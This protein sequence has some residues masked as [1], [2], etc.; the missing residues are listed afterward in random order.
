MFRYLKLYKSSKIKSLEQEILSLK[1]K[2]EELQQQKHV[3]LDEDQTKKFLNDLSDLMEE[4][5]EK[6]IKSAPETVNLKKEQI[7][8]GI[9]WIMKWSIGLA[10]IFLSICAI[11]G[12]FSVYNQMDISG[13]YKVIAIIIFVVSA[14]DFL[15]LGIGIIRE[16]DR[17]YIVALFSAIVALAAL[18]IALFK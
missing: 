14:F 3:Y 10:L 5:T 9:S 1:V 16:K 11:C 8:D 12:S 13:W 17:D 7:N 15:V 18:V 2:V 4:K 6:I